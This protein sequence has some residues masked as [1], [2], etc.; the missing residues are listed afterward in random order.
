M[1]KDSFTYGFEIEGVF[2]KSLI[3]NLKK[4]WQCDE[5]TD[6]SVRTH[7]ILSNVNTRHVLAERTQ[8][9]NVGIFEKQDDLFTALKMVNGRTHFFNDSC[10]LHLH[11]RPKTNIEVI[12]RRVIDLEFIKKVEKFA[13]DNLCEH[14]KAR[15][16]NQYC[17]VHKGLKAT[18]YDF[19]VREKYRFIRLHPHYNTFEMRFFSPCEHKV[20]N[21]KTFLDYFISE[22]SKIDD[23]KKGVFIIS[24]KKTEVIAEGAFKLRFKKT[25]NLAFSHIVGKYS[26]I[27]NERK[28]GSSFLSWGKSISYSKNILDRMRINERGHRRDCHCSIECI[29]LRINEDCRCSRCD[30]R[31]DLLYHDYDSD[32]DCQRCND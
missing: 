14:V 5:K 30:E 23:T 21:I 9:I 26:R 27:E 20:K 29:D 3:K 25:E 13:H 10:G 11:I 15:R 22:L 2:T 6:G 16:N 24:D 1:N 31:Y 12:Q 8:E 18:R 7:A 4:K 32:C 28:F 17:S 19:Q